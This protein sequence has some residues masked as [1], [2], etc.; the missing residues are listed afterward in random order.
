MNYFGFDRIGKTELTDLEYHNN[1]IYDALEG[2][3]TLAMSI[4][5]END[6]DVLSATHRLIREQWLTV[7]SLLVNNLDEEHIPFR[8]TLK[9][10][11][12]LKTLLETAGAAMLSL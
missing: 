6:P 12:E 10:Q 3:Y 5:G 9:E 2:I 4:V 1:V 8:N 7:T 11:T